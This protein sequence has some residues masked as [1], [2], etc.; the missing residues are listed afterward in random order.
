MLA[1]SNQVKQGGRAKRLAA[2]PS[3][4]CDDLARRRCG[5]D[6]VTSMKGG[7]RAGSC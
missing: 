3:A 7:S 6:R 4:F 2:W 1:P 5:H